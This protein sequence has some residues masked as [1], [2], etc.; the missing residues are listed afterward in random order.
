MCGSRLT[1]RYTLL[2]VLLSLPLACAA[3]MRTWTDRTGQHRTEA[4]L[5]E[6][7]DGQVRLRKPD[8]QIVTLALDRLSAEDQSYLQERVAPSAPDAETPD[9]LAPSDK[10]VV[11]EF[12]SGAKMTGRITARDDEYVM[13]EA[14]VSGRTFSR[15]YPTRSIQAVTVDGNRI[16]LGASESTVAKSSAGPAVEGV[17]R[18]RE[19][20][21]RLIDELGRTPPDWWDSTPLN[22]PE[23]L[24]L[25][26]P[27]K[28]PEPWNAQKNVGQY[29]WDIIDPNPSKWREG[30]RL[31]HFLLDRHKQ[32]PEKRQRAMETLGRLYFL[33]LRD[34]ARA[35]FWWR[36]AGV[37]RQA[38]SPQGVELAECFWRL[39]NK[40]MALDML[41]RNKVYFT[42]IKLLAD[43][44]ETRRALQIADAAAR[45]GWADLGYLYAGDACR[46]EGRYDEA[47]RYYQ[48]VLELKA[49]PQQEKRLERN[50]TRARANIQAIKIYDN[51]DLRRIPDGTYQG[52]SPGYVADIHVEVTIRQ[53]RIVEVRVTD[54]KEKQYYGALAETPAKIIDKQG[55]KGV[56]ATTSATITSEAIINATALALSKGLR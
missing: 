40:Q 16:V 7:R 4:E 11:I 5:V 3:E 48:Q 51:L 42:T 37:E 6:F 12:G 8:G 32:D 44:G 17:P 25:N 43:M 26:W 49:G 47:L 55:V 53:G 35:A 52:A 33:L 41:N 9:P 38:N 1:V 15:R 23:T 54:H 39:G 27:A 2:A 28:A 29:I 56:D 10:T 50:Q 34:H 19:E 22:Y 14:E 18:T 36:Q 21:N 20:I 45:G 30:V 31:V 13:M 24:D 46:I